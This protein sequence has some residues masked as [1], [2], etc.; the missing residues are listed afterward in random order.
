MD[1]DPVLRY[2]FDPMSNDETSLAAVEQ[3]LIREVATI[4]CKDP[5]AIRSDVSLPSLGVD[6]LGFVELLVMIEKVFSLRLIESGLTREDFE[7]IHAL[8]TRISKGLR[9]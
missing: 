5:A 6:S 2:K 4:L 8:A 9:G 1:S 3:R 7:T